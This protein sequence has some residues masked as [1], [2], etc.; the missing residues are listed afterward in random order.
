MK[1]IV[2][3]GEIMGRINPAGF[4][5][6]RQ[7]FPGTAELSFAGSEANVAVSVSLLGG[8]TRF[9]TALPKHSVAQAVSTRYGVL[10]SI[11]SRSCEPIPGDW[12]FTSSKP[13]PTNAPVR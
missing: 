3:F 6:N 10:A 11:P 9:V 7:A 4:G 13:E 8:K 2:T 1:T 12:A 5:R